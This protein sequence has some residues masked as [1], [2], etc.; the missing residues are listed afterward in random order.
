[1]C[2]STQTS[3]HAPGLRELGLRRLF[4]V[5]W[6]LL[7][8][9]LLL[10]RSRVFP[11][12]ASQMFLMRLRVARVRIQSRYF[13]AGSSNKLQMMNP[14]KTE[15]RTLVCDCVAITGSPIFKLV[16]FCN[17]LPPSDVLERFDFEA[18][19]CLCSSAEAAAALA[20]FGDGASRFFSRD[21]SRTSS[22]RTAFL[23][24]DWNLRGELHCGV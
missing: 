4:V 16:A 23:I 15:A 7:L 12:H 24:C 2:A 17:R 8:L 13:E 22:I 14:L 5:L 21:F 10:L 11:A 18:S 19:S 9:V 20:F 1:M 3:L 6:V